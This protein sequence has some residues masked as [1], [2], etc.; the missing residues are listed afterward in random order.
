MLWEGVLHPNGTADAYPD[1]GCGLPSW[2]QGQGMPISEGL[3]PCLFDIRADPTEHVDLNEGG[4]AA[5]DPAL[6][7]VLSTMEARYRARCDGFFQSSHIF[8]DPRTQ[9]TRR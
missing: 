9:V 6:A 4:V 8:S 5:K 7:Q 2:Q 1:R 3:A